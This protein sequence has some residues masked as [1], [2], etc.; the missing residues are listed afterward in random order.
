MEVALSCG[1]YVYR[2]SFSNLGK[3]NVILKY[4]AMY[5]EYMR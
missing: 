5:A 3:I 4:N 1:L 2:I